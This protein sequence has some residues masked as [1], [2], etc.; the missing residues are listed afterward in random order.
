MQEELEHKLNFIIKEFTDAFLL[1][2]NELAL[3][4]E[5]TQSRIDSS[6]LVNKVILPNE[7]RSRMGRAPIEGG[8]IPLEL[9][10]QQASE[11]ITDGKGTRAR[12]QERTVNTSDKSNTARNAQGEGRKQK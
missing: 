5:E 8:D 2:F 1:R 7:V 11:A 10:P 9:K 4:D 12:D 3:T 6:Y